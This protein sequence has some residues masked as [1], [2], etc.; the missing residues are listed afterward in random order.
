[1]DDNKA[2]VATHRHKR[3][4]RLWLPLFIVI[5]AIA[6]GANIILFVKYRAA[7]STNPVS[8]QREL[9]AAVAHIAV[10]PHETPVVS[11]VADKQKLNNPA[12]AA[13]V[14]NGDKILIYGQAKRLIVYRPSVHKIVTMLTIQDA[15]AG[16]S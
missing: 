2:A 1:M 13:V 12:L 6:V 10:V 9:Q 5:L 15:P 7:V 4:L 8:Q 14:Q 16:A 11:T 3:R